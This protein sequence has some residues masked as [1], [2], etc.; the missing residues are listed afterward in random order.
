MQCVMYVIIYCG[1]GSYLEKFCFRSQ[2]YLAQFF[3]DKKLYKGLPF[4]C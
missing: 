2:T 1:F 4:Q 3:N